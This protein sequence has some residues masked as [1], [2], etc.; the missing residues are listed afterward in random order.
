MAK[1]RVYQ[2]AQDINMK[3]GEVVDIL[4]QFGVPVKS[5]SSTIDESVA[6]MVK[7]RLGLDKPAPEVEPEEEREEAPPDEAPVREE[8]PPA[9]PPTGPPAP[10]EQPPLERKEVPEQPPA[11]QET[12]RPA[13]TP[14]EPVAP[15]RPEHTPEPPPVPEAAVP[16]ADAE[17][18]ELITIPPTIIIKDLAGLIDATPA[19]LIAKLISRGVMKSANQPIASDVA[20]TLLAEMGYAVEVKREQPEPGQ[21][22]SAE[23]GRLVE[24]APV[25][26]V[27]GHVDHGKTTLLD[28]LRN[29]HVTDQEAG[30]ITQHIGASE[31]VY[32]GRRIV[33]L[34]TPGHAAFTAMRARGAHLTDIAVLVVAADDGIMPQTVEA[35][36]HAKAAGVPLIVAINKIDRPDANPDRVK[37]QLTEYGLVPEDW[38]GDT[39]CVAVSALEGTG[40]DDLL[41]MILLVAEMRELRADPDAPVRGVVIEARLDPQQGPTATILVQ[42]GTLRVGDY[43]VAGAESGRVRSM[44]N[45]LGEEVETAGPSTPVNLTGLGGVPLASDPVVGAVDSRAAKQLANRYREE[46]R[47]GALGIDHR[48]S[49]EDLFEQIKGGTVQELNIIVKA[50]VQGSVEALCQALGQLVFSKVRTNVVHAAVGTINE[51]DVTLAAASNA[52]I[53]GFHVTA[54]AGAMKVAE[55]E[56]VEIRI[57]NII[58]EVLEDIKAAL[59]GLLEP[60]I[61]ERVLGHAEVRALF[62]S[63]RAGT[64]AG[65]MVTDGR[66]VRGK[67]LR[68]LRDGEEVFRGELTSLRH[69]TEARAEIPVGMECGVS[70]EGFDDLRE[71]DVL[72]CLDLVKVARR[73]S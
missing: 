13:T 71:G 19:E 48:V 46:A 1:I 52:I 43:L 14:T 4:N 35:I 21:L 65:C 58:Y 2:L 17:G 60:V 33:F 22:D 36:H 47:A 67:P 42:Q 72:E 10:P 44:K 63:S 69:L 39:V 6:Y 57:Y 64:I 59:A 28:A 23:A 62:R 30:H 8:E 66:L 26:T 5:H 51:S 29:T 54:D 37:Q 70:L 24:V 25:V 9:P 38:G 61:E 3:A 18:R 16:R 7:Q 32:A 11:P 40:L 73:L 53:I 45:W 55:R 68:V 27:M 31:I 20:S 12:A 41:E 56:H 34:D 49:L 50:D 15:P